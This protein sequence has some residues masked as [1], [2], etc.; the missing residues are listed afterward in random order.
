MYRD[1]ERTG[2][3]FDR[4]QYK[5]VKAKY[6]QIA[7]EKLAE[8]KK[9][10]DINWNSSDQKAKVLFG[11]EGLPVLKVSKKT[12]NPSAYKKVMNRLASKGYELPTMILNY[13]EANTLNKMFLNR[14]GDDSS[15]DGRIHPNFQLTS[16]V[17]GRTACT[18][19]N[20]QQVPRCKDVRALYH[21]PKGRVFF[22]ADYSQ[23]ELRIAAHY[24][25]EPTMLKIYKNNGDIHT[26]TAKILTNGR[27]PTKEE[28]GKA[29]A[30]NFG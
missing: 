28:R 23:L 24:A 26:E 10:Y 13:N 3:Y 27:D 17:S 12:G 1:V 15:Y 16:V 9:R 25:N 29:K 6:K 7:D 19:P 20:L 2:I 4:K 8:L 11:D 18:D 30:I 14:W 21:A 22:E 5:V